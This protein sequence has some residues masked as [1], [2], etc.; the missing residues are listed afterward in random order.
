MSKVKYLIATA[1]L[2]LAAANPAHA[3]INAPVPVSDY[4]T[5]GGLDWAWAQPCAAYGSSCGPVDLS[6][7]SSQG[8][9]FPT[10]DE[11]LARP[12]YTDFGGKCAAAY[13]GGWS[14]CDFSDAASGYIFD[15]GH[16]VLP[17]GSD[18]YSESWVVRGAQGAVPEPATWAMMIAGFGAVG[19]AMRRRRNVKV[20]FA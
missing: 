3:A 4:I 19:F 10:L 8:W 17:L 20:S 14:H 7:Q 13:F 2:A 15:Y 9:R 18:Y 5:F 6:Y 11:F 12:D 16:N 1:G